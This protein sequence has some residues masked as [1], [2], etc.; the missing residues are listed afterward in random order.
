M[1]GITLSVDG[2]RLSAIVAGV[3][4][5]GRWGA[6]YD[7]SQ[8][9]SLIQ[10]AL[11]AGITTFD[12][13]DIYGGYTTEAEFG[14]ALALSPHLRRKMQ[15]VTKCGICLE[16]PNRPENRLKSY[17]TSKEYIIRSAER[18][19]T[20]LGTDYI[21]LL[22]I[23]RPDPLM[24]A[25]E[26]AEAIAALKRQGKVRYFGVS[27][28]LPHQVE[29][30]RQATPIVTNQVEASLL[31]L[32]PLYD[33]TFDQCQRLGMRPMVWSPIGGGTYFGEGNAAVARLRPVVQEL[34]EQ[35][36]NPGEEVILLAW[37][38]RH[39]AGPIPVVGTTKSERLIRTTKALDL[40]LDRQD[41]FR[42]LEA[43]RGQKVA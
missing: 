37:L 9:L 6:Q 26:V 39:P 7:E 43:A 25:Q 16:S 33:G 41:W 36:G 35:Y 42:L 10:V 27:N 40:T 12:H 31:R 30:I 19:L 29:L 38:L 21:D 1:D 5:W 13:A 34:N 23:H 18:S 28:F 20:N 4:T 22:L 11:D 17:N 2:P 3:M 24:N 14:Q 8:M 32:D 15:L